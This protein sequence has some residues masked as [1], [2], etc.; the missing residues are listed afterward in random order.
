MVKRTEVLNLQAAPQRI[1]P[2]DGKPLKL[3]LACG[4]NKKIGDYIGIDIA[5]TDAADYVFD[6][7]KYP[8]P[9]D[10][11]TVDEIHCCHFFEHI[12]GPLR[13]AF[14]D[15]CYRVLKPKTFVQDDANVYSMKIIVPYWT[16][17][18]S[19]QDPTHAWPPVCEASFVYFNKQWRIDNKLEHYPVTCD[20]NFTTGYFFDSEMTTR[21][22]PWQAFAMK[23]YLNTALDLH[24]NLTRKG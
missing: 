17:M 11:Q 3:D 7:L 20:F 14:M 6:L 22:Q 10:D 21:S 4:N 19:I 1:R 5:K 18:R 15:E 23:H 12:P 16:S 9:I 2:V 24:V 8:W 13:F